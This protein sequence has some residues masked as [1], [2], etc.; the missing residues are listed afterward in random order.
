MNSPQR[1]HEIRL[2]GLNV[3][4]FSGVARGVPRCDEAASVS[5]PVSYTAGFHGAHD[6]WKTRCGQDRAAGAAIDHGRVDPSASARGRTEG[7]PRRTRRQA[8][9]C[10][11]HG[12][13]ASC[14]SRN[15]RREMGAPSGWVG[16]NFH[17][18]GFVRGTGAQSIQPR[19]EAAPPERP[20]VSTSLPLLVVEMA[21][22]GVPLIVI[23][24]Q[25]G[26]ATSASPRSTCRASTAARS[27]ETVH[28]R[29]AP[30]MPVSVSLRLGS[31]REQRC[32]SR[33]AIQSDGTVSHRVAHP[34][35]Q[36]GLLPNHSGAS[37]PGRPAARNR[38]DAD[39]LS[40]PGRSRRDAR[41]LSERAAHPRLPEWAEEGLRARTCT[42]SASSP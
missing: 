6:G 22:E 34:G 17:L 13:T 18:R 27:M 24:R 35:P 1:L 11:M 32:S 8:S 26:A 42:R 12:A 20:A 30:M 10:G 28:A 3:V 31:T 23:Q 14:A 41:P 38:A 25:F 5:I 33:I 21:R 16:V 29:R 2:R 19:R 37:D 4:P 36:A 39:D 9:L 40:Q 7:Y 15:R